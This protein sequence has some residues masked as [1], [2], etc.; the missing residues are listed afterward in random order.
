ME[1]LFPWC[2]KNKIIW[3]RLSS[4]KYPTNFFSE[5]LLHHFQASTLRLKSHVFYTHCW[6]L[7]S[8][9]SWLFGFIVRFI[10][11]CTVDKRERTQAICFCLTKSKF[12]HDKRWLDCKGGILE[13]RR[14][15]KYSSKGSGKTNGRCRATRELFIAYSICSPCIFTLTFIFTLAN[16]PGKALSELHCNYPVLRKPTVHLFLHV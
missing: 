5:R 7:S 6:V 9:D 13:H 3:I 14:P 15:F 10:E 2:C 12:L 1:N 16:H 4:W 8:I 11:N